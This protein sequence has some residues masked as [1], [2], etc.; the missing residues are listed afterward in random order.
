MKLLAACA[1]ALCTALPAQA[2]TYK[3]VDD[4]G[5]TNY[6]ST[7]PAGKASKTKVI[8]DQIS[9]VPTDPDFE[10]Q[11][12]ALRKR[13]ARRA[14][15]EE[16]EFRRRQQQQ[17][18]PQPSYTSSAPEYTDEWWYGGGYGYGY[19]RPIHGRPGRPTHPIARPGRPV[20]PEMPLQG[21]PRAPSRR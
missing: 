21:A 16:A 10:R 7:P 20:Q 11:A 8:E 1:I 19:Y 14:E 17:P 3:W 13:E 18:A 12:E 2:Q 9:V 4:K 5:V 6:S 15:R